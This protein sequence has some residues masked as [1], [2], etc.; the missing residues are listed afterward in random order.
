MRTKFEI[1]Y[2]IVTIFKEV[3]QELMIKRRWKYYPFFFFFFFPNCCKDTES[4]TGFT[5][6]QPKAALKC[7]GQVEWWQCSYYNP[8]KTKLT[9]VTTI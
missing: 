3:L 4:Y 9:S 6:W 5:H 8:N 1:S 2:N 7:D